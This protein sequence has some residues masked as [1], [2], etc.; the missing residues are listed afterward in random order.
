V[1]CI[2]IIGSNIMQFQLLN[3]SLRF[4]CLAQW[5]AFPL[6]KLYTEKMFVLLRTERIQLRNHIDAQ[7]VRC[8]QR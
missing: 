7:T 1:K 4:H 2:E 3:M 5:P 8:S 6:R